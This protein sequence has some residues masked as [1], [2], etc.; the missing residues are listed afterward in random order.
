MMEKKSEGKSK[1]PHTV[2]DKM[3][4]TVFMLLLLAILSWVL[5]TIWFSVSH[6]ESSQVQSLI[7]CELQSLVRFDQTKLKTMLDW[8]RPIEQ[9]INN[10]N[11]NLSLAI[12]MPLQIVVLRGMVF[13]LS[14]PLFAIIWFVFVVDG[15][16]QR[17]IRKYQGARES[18]FVFHRLKLLTGT[19]FYLLFF[20]YMAMPL[21]FAPGIVL[22]PM[23]LLSGVLI[24]LSVTHFKKYL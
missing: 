10:S 21:A 20:V 15:L 14:L 11:K 2:I 9:I 6:E 4:S 23:A 17:D 5:L 22:L 18:A 1:R 16:A 8:F 12:I 19:V 7:D 3:L 24:Q 13:I